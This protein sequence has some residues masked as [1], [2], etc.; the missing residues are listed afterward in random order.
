MKKDCWQLLKQGD[1]Y[2]G[3]YYS[4]PSTFAFARNFPFNYFKT[5]SY[6]LSSTCQYVSDAVPGN[7]GLTENKM[8]T[9]F[10]EFI[11]HGGN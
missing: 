8:K 11:V 1:E 3:I 2:I 6:L 7:G 10:Q 5:A 4:V 9:L